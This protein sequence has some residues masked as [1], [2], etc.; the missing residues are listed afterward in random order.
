MSSKFVNSPT[1]VWKESDSTG[2]IWK[3]DTQGFIPNTAT[4]ELPLFQLDAYDIFVVHVDGDLTL[5]PL[6]LSGQFCYNSVSAELQ[7]QS[8]ELSSLLRSGNSIGADLVLPFIRLEGYGTQID[9]YALFEFEPLELEG[10]SGMEGSLVLEPLSLQSFEAL[11]NIVYITLE[12]LELEGGV[13]VSNNHGRLTL[14]RLL[15]GGYSGGH[16]KLVFPKMEIEGYSQNPISCQGVLHLPH[17]EYSATFGVNGS[18]ELPPLLLNALMENPWSADGILALQPPSL[19]ATLSNSHQGTG[20]LLFR[21][22]SVEGSLNYQA[23]FSITGQLTLRR[24][25]FKSCISKIKSAHS[26]INLPSLVVSAGLST[27]NPCAGEIT[28][29]LFSMESTLH[30]GALGYG[31]C[32]PAETF[33]Y[34]DEL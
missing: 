26:E 5:E 31:E 33:L 6:E 14:P 25:G 28:L 30:Q 4:L 27:P 12:P 3:W 18:I 21:P 9:N 2:G 23:P 20:V 17:M 19:S 15:L 11:D 10:Y 7:F 13:R 8:I 34:K 32:S 24:L 29:G 22:I 16:V 1:G